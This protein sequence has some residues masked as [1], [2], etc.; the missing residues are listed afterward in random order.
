MIG[1]GRCA[2][3]PPRNAAD[4]T[5]SRD[6]NAAR[7]PRCC[8]TSPAVRPILRCSLL[9]TDRMPHPRLL[10]LALAAPL[11]PPVRATDP[12]TARLAARAIAMCRAGRAAPSLGWPGW[13]PKSAIKP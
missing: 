6:A 8:G 2:P 3:T 9:A 7:P 10:L 5:L 11:L 1:H 4:A 12:T 13:P